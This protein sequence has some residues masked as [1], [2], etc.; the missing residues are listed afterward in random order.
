MVRREL[1]LESHPNGQ[2]DYTGVDEGGDGEGAGQGLNQYYAVY[3]LNSEEVSVVIGGQG[4]R[5]K[6]HA[7]PRS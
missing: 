5:W 4:I 3:T 7:Q 1:I 6:Q 2:A